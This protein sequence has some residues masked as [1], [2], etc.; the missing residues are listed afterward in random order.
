MILYNVKTSIFAPYDTVIFDLDG[1]VWN[2]YNPMG[3]LIPALALVPPFTL[4]DGNTVQDIRGNIARLAEDLRDVLS[5]L[6]KAGINLGIV[7]HSEVADTVEQAQPAYMLLR[8]F[9]L[10]QFFTY[11]VVIKKDI[12]KSLYVR[13][14]GKTLFIDDDQKQL[15][16]VNKRGLADVLNRHSFV[17]FKDLFTE[18]KEVP[19]EPEFKMQQNA[20]QPTTSSWKDSLNKFAGLA[21]SDMGDTFTPETKFVEGWWSPDGHEY[22]LSDFGVRAHDAAAFKIIEE[23]SAYKSEFEKG[24]LPPIEFLLDKGWLRLAFDSVTIGDPRSKDLVRKYIE[25]FSKDKPLHVERYVHMQYYFIYSG[26]VG[27]FLERFESLNFE[28]RNYEKNKGSETPQDE[29]VQGDTSR[30]DQPSGTTAPR[31]T[32]SVQPPIQRISPKV[33]DAFNQK[34]R[35][36][37]SE[38][39]LRAYRR[40]HPQYRQ[41]IQT[42]VSKPFEQVNGIDIHED[43]DHKTAALA[44]ALCS[45]DTTPYKDQIVPTALGAVRY[46]LFQNGYEFPN[47]PNYTDILWNVASGNLDKQKA[48]DQ[49]VRFLDANLQPLSEENGAVWDQTGGT[50]ASLK[51]SE[52][53]LTY[54]DKSDIDEGIQRSNAEFFHQDDHLDI[55]NQRDHIWG[56]PWEPVQQMFLD[57]NVEPTLE[58]K[59]K[60]QHP[61]KGGIATANLRTNAMTFYQY[62]QAIIEEYVRGHLED[63]TYND[64]METGELVSEIMDELEGYIT[65]P[66][67]KK[68]VEAY[69]RTRIPGVVNEL[70]QD[71]SEVSQEES[72]MDK[73]KREKREQQKAVAD[74][75][76][77]DAPDFLLKKFMHEQFSVQAL[78]QMIKQ[79]VPGG[80]YLSDPEIEELVNSLAVNDPKQFTQNGNL[81]YIGDISQKPVADKV[82]MNMDEFKDIALKPIED[83]AQ[84]GEL[85]QTPDGMYVFRD[86]GS[87]ILGI[88]HLDTV[89]NLSHFEVQNLDDTRV[90]RN[91]QLDDRLGA[92][93]ILSLLP[94][95]GVNCDI[96]LTEGEEGG[97]ST[98]LY[99]EPTKKYNWIFEFDRMGMDVVMYQY[100]DKPTE[101]MMGKEG[102]IPA[103]GSFS[104]ISMMEHLGVKGFNFGTGFYDYHGKDSHAI[105]SHV[106]HNVKLF[107]QFYD[108]YKNTQLPHKNSGYYTGRRRKSSLNITFGDFDMP[109][110]EQY[111]DYMGTMDPSPKDPKHF[112]DQQEEWSLRKD[113]EKMYFE[114]SMHNDVMVRPETDRPVTPFA[115]LKFASMP[116]HTDVRLH[117]PNTLLVHEGVFDALTFEESEKGGF[118]NRH[119]IRDDYLYS[120]PK[121]GE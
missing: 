26:T 18:V 80:Q 96:L 32:Q 119:E 12:D 49:I 99:F 113:L 6:D 23:I 62:T 46:F 66:S 17:G 10:L 94:Q 34:Y 65:N 111:D 72:W 1:D 77:K 37:Y 63:Q 70:G 15:D 93:V 48:Y 90:V 91:A 55:N 108:K 11:I 50:L 22:R 21:F 97:H 84:F 57:P 44:V 118:M 116:F 52:D 40:L 100:H 114:R 107:K 29:A 5:S 4:L 109:K 35:E 41:R 69:L 31:G 39:E 53:P 105:E 121:V 95:L 67:V 19:D 7:S 78:V 30:R 36:T 25:H 28:G 75:A 68:E 16:L 106:L 89:Q 51:F 104:D 8:K 24:D 3:D 54:T 14:E 82:E 47:L 112:E 27:D 83:F 86:N 88:A 92:Y 33:I 43:I 58:D 64:A 98:G 101:E 2:C 87:N 115:S 20:P 38:D 76:K 85:K 9:A 120:A 74:Q 102:F 71:R 79:Y 73:Y 60:M 103:K 110:G 45:P 59:I 61:D 13:P 56:E 42:A 117:K 81:I